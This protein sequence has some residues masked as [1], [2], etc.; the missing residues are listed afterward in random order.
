MLFYFTTKQNKYFKGIG[1][2][3]NVHYSIPYFLRLYLLYF[4]PKINF[5]VFGEDFIVEVNRIKIKYIYALIYIILL[6]SL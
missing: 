6:F 2:D 4:S 3:F 5:Y 1:L